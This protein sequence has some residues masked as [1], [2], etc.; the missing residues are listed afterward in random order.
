[1]SKLAVW[2][3]KEEWLADRYIDVD[4]SSNHLP[5]CLLK[6][7]RIESSYN[8]NQGSH[9][10]NGRKTRNKRFAIDLKRLVTRSLP[11]DLDPTMEFYHVHLIHSHKKEFACRI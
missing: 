3:R 9:E 7:E 11:L 4:H 10:V 1:M 5:A 2:T 6:K 8:E